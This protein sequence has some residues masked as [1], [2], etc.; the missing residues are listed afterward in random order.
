MRLKT[1]GNLAS[2]KNLKKNLAPEFGICPTLL[3]N[4]TSTC[5]SNETN[6]DCYQLAFQFFA[7]WLKATKKSLQRKYS[8]KY[9]NDP[10]FF[11][12]YYD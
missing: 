3:K 11:Q 2:D 1:G 8:R 5:S 6:K 10:L 12:L 7:T 9:E 4:C